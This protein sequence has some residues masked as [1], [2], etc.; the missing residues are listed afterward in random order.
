M[1]KRN[2]PHIITFLAFAIFI[3]LGLACASTPMVPVELSAN[4]RGFLSQPAGNER[5]IDTVYVRGSTS[6][7]CRD[8][9]HNITST[10]VLGSTYQVREDSGFQ[11]HKD[12][13]VFGQL[14]NEAKRQYPNE[15]IDV[16]NAK[17]G[18]HIPTNAR[19]EVYTESVS[20]RDDGSLASVERM[21][22]IWDCF[23]YYSADVITTE[24]WPQPVAHSE[25]FQVPGATRADNYRNAYFWVQD[26][27][28]R[29]RLS[30]IE[31]NIDLG[32]IRGT[33]TT[34]ARA[35]QTYRII[36]DFTVRV[37]DAR[38][39][40]NFSEAVLRRIDIDTGKITGDPEPIFLQSIADAA[41]SELLDF[42]TALRS[43]IMASQ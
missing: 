39:E 30:G 40:I 28:T 4:Y 5:V 3:V 35:D 38:I 14:L 32:Q 10:Q 17:T 41:A 27:T 37:F 6:F 1:N 31:G 29:R 9:Q 24:P 16:K 13:A 19:H 7:V 8:P 42:S 26:N 18:G 15:K 11:S 25:T 21:R 2:L 20:R 33:V 36:S 34:S 43:H 23:L 12:E 22:P